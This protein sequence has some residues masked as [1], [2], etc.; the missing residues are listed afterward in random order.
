MLVKDLSPT[1]PS[2]AACKAVGVMF[3]SA[4]MAVNTRADLAALSG[5]N[6]PEEKRP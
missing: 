4:A 1:S 5:G 3:A 6:K 2:D